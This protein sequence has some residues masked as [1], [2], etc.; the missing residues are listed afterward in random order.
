M[1]EGFFHRARLGNG[2]ALAGGSIV[3]PVDFPMIF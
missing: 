1:T 2:N 3:V